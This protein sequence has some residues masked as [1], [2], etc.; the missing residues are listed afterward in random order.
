MVVPGQ[1]GTVYLLR[2][3][4]AW[5]GPDLETRVT[6]LERADTVGTLETLLDW[7]ILEALLVTADFE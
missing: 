4:L 6:L 2:E 5:E 7:V 1:L 3:L